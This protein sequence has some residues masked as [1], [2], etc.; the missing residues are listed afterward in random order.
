MEVL[1]SRYSLKSEDNKQIALIITVGAPVILKLLW[2]NLLWWYCYLTEA[3]PKCS[4]LYSLKTVQPTHRAPRFLQWGRFEWSPPVSH[5]P[6]VS[7][8]AL[9]S[10]FISD[11]T[12][13]EHFFMLCQAGPL[14]CLHKPS[15]AHLLSS[16]TQTAFL[17]HR[18]FVLWPC[19]FAVAGWRG[20]LPLCRIRARSVAVHIIPTSV[21]M[22][23]AVRI[24]Q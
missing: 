8:A 18:Q 13:G 2:Q 4:Q 9:W 21:Q 17:F 24:R 23:V 12:T 14:C 20:P 22:L 19:F 3:K 5:T 6:P 11:K 10:V 15:L 1:D 7:F 16:Q